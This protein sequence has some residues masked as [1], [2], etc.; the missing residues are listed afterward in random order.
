MMVAEVAEFLD[1]PLP[2]FAQ[3]QPRCIPF[4]SRLAVALFYEGLH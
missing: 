1:S 3:Q 2:L 4:I